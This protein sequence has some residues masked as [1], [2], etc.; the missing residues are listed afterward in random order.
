[1]RVPLKVV[2]KFLLPPQLDY[3]ERVLEALQEVHHT[4]E[5]V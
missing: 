4:V 5:I 2:S 3:M 1:M